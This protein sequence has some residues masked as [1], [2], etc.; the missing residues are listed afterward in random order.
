MTGKI[1]GKID[2]AEFGLCPDRPFLLG[3][4]L[5]VSSDKY[6]ICDGFKYTVNISDKCRWEKE[7]RNACIAK[8]LGEDVVKLLKGAKV[9]YV[10][11]LIGKP[12]E[13]T[14]ENNTFKDFRILTE[15]L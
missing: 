14:V 3:V 1:L 15:C 12:V 11:E 10:S 4:Q 8:V 13:I 6:F 2:F 7:D 5:W 9:N